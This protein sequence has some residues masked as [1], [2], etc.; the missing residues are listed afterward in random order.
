MTRFSTAKSS[1]GDT[2]T[3]TCNRAF[4]REQFDALVEVFWA[5]YPQQ[6]PDGKAL[7]FPSGLEVTLKVEKNW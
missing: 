4:T 5:F 3:L 7:A 2:I 1:T 6:W